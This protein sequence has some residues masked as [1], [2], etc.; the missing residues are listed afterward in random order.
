MSLFLAVDGSSSFQQHVVCTQTTDVICKIVP[1]TQFFVSIDSVFEIQ[2]SYRKLCEI[3]SQP[4]IH[5]PGTSMDHDICT[6]FLCH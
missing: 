2:R 1:P 4:T 3:S 5:T 6:Y